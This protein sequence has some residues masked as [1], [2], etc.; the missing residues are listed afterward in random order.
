M[1]PLPFTAALL[2]IT[3]VKAG[4]AIQD[5]WSGVPGILGPVLEWGM[6][7]YSDYGADPYS[8]PGELMLSGELMKHQVT[9]TFDGAF[10]VDACDIDGDGHLDVLGGGMSDAAISWWRNADGTGTQWEQHQITGMPLIRRAVCA[11]VNSDGFLDAVACGSG[12]SVCWYENVDGSGTGWITHWVT[13]IGSDVYYLDCSDFNGDGW[14]DI[15]AAEHFNDRVSWWENA[16]GTGENWSERVVDDDAGGPYCTVAWDMDIDGDTDILGSLFS[17]MMICWWENQDGQGTAWTKHQVGGA[18]M[19]PRYLA[20]CDVDGDGDPDVLSTGY[21]EVLCWEN[22]NGMATSWEMH[23]ID[24]DF[25]GAHDVHGSDLDGDGDQDVLTASFNTE[26]I[27]WWE[28][29]DGAGTSWSEHMLDGS[30]EDACA[31]D[32]AD[33]DGNGTPDPVGAAYLADEI[34]WWNLSAYTSGSLESSILDTGSQPD[35]DMLQIMA[36]T[37]PGTCVS[38]QLRCSDDHAQM[39]GWTDT[40]QA[41][42][43]LEGV[44]E[45]GRRYLQYRVILNSEDQSS[46]PVLDEISISWNPLGLE[47]PDPASTGLTVNPNPSRGGSCLRIGL[48]LRSDVRLMVFDMT[49]RLVWES[50][51]EFR[52]GFSDVFLTDIHSGIYLC[53]M[54]VGDDNV[55]ARMVILD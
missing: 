19:D 55:S 42:L 15:V 21:Q 41:P 39:G 27:L 43:S 45:D 18:I 11:D 33:I 28:N 22:T 7:F 29:T 32:A 10:S 9:G 37:P 25:L 36:E 40:L 3:S 12:G 50:S 49:G 23:L 51:G 6:D 44:L 26:E 1:R 8:V 14:N 46:T 54:S 13:L 35:W 20:P 47:G 16:D 2:L 53:R 24:D 30:F 52:A 4:T 31:V 48:P 34:A 5:D 17:D 38:C